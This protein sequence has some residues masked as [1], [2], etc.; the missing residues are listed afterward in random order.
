MIMAWIGT[1]ALVCDMI[2]AWH[3]YKSRNIEG[4]IFWC[5]LTLT[6]AITLY[7]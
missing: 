1:F 6:V 2:M 4:V 5:A 3:N 7:R